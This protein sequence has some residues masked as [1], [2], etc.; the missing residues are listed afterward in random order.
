MNDRGVAVY[1]HG[2][3]SPTPAEA[4]GDAAADITDGQFAINTELCIYKLQTKLTHLAE[5]LL[6]SLP[7]CWGTNNLIHSHHWIS[8]GACL[9]RQFSSDWNGQF[10]SGEALT[11]LFINQKC[12]V[13]T[14]RGGTSIPPDTV[15]FRHELNH[16][17]EERDLAEQW[18]ELNPSDP[19]E[20]LHS[21]THLKRG[22][23][24]Q[25]CYF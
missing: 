5:Q 10:W 23:T 25:F 6:A 18:G 3:W 22:M 17:N 21:R 1:Q 11:E 13:Q 20:L 2:S 9:I 12:A 24:K 19:K 16:E 14:C 15:F 4:V 7:N 8:L